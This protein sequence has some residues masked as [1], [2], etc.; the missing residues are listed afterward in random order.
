[1][2]SSAVYTQSSYVTVQYFII[3]F[4]EFKSIF[5]FS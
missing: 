5:L 2:I 4:K 1:M 3:Q